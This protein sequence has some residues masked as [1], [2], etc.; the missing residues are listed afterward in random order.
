MPPMGTVEPA[1]TPQPFSQNDAAVYG[2]GRHTWR[3]QQDM[4][5]ERKAGAWRFTHSK[6]STY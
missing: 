3:L 6:A 1:R 5:L 2:G 4:T